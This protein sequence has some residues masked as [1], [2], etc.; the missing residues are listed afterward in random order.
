MV[1]FACYELRTTDPA[2]ARRFYAAVLGAT[3]LEIADLPPGAA[4]H[5]APA[6][7]LGH[8]GVDDVEG[9][10]RAF[11]AHGAARLGPP[12]A[13]RAGGEAV[14]VRD[15]G[16]AVVALATPKEREPR[17]PV[18]WHQL[19]TGDLAAGSACYRDALGWALTERLDLGPFGVHQEFAWAPGGASVGSMVHT[20][21]LAGAHPHWLFH[22]GVA[23]LEPAL[24]A[25]QAGG[26]SLVGPFLLAG[27]ARV[28]VCQDPQ[29]AAFAL[30]AAG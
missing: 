17:A 2:A 19:H 11:E 24:A 23:A 30:R 21:S 22:F 26:G 12:L 18:V 1:R 16:G 3:A 10:A 28:A 13:T 7:W 6:H 15:P 20:A 27:G 5:G 29:G 4:A 25:V 9:A 8:L 14:V